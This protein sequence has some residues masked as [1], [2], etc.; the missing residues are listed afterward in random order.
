MAT[1]VTH[2][3]YLAFSRTHGSRSMHHEIQ[4]AASFPFQRAQPIVEQLRPEFVFCDVDGLPRF[5]SLRF[6]HAHV[7]IY[8]VADAEIARKLHA[9]SEK[10]LRNPEI[11]KTLIAQG[12]DITA[13]PPD[14]FA[15]VLQA[16]FDRWSA[17]V[18][19]AGVKAN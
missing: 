12:W 5:G 6:D 15:T 13:S 10:V 9:D 1:A 11:A 14:R 17:V 16:E 2:G 7:V 19:G 18:K 4:L 3:G 8:E